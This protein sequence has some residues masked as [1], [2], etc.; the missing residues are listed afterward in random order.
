MIG[1]LKGKNFTQKFRNRK[2]I[3][4]I[5]IITRGED[6]RTYRALVAKPSRIASLIAYT[7][8]KYSERL[9]DI[10]NTPMPMSLPLIRTGH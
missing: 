8:M 10:H 1:S 3:L 4:K 7:K 9:L 6:T 2:G 5:Y